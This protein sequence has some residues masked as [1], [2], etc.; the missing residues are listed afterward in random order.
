MRK[1]FFRKVISAMLALSLVIAML[2]A[3]AAAATA[4]DYDYVF[5]NAA[6]ALPESPTRDQRVLTSG[7]HTIDETDA[8]VS[9]SWGFVNAYGY[10]GLATKENAINWEIQENEWNIIEVIQ[11]LW[12][13]RKRREYSKTKKKFSGVLQ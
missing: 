7:L 13:K 4:A 9:S 5:T 12:N 11:K 3:T 8:S 6:H 1:E 2:P 10:A